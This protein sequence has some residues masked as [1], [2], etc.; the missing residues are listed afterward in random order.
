MINSSLFGKLR[1]NEFYFVLICQTN[2]MNVPAIIGFDKSGNSSF[3]SFNKGNI[4]ADGIEIYIYD[5]KTFVNVTNVYVFSRPIGVFEDMN[6]E[7]EGIFERLTES[8]KNFNSSFDI[9]KH[10]IQMYGKNPGLPVLKPSLF[11]ESK[12]SSYVVPSLFSESNNSSY[13]VPSLFSESGSETSLNRTSSKLKKKK[14][15]K[16]KSPKKKSPK[17]NF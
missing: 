11:S 13:V 4:T 16:K 17:K 8:S 10:N 15:P 7:E 5:P 12:K 1:S 6:K 3:Y 9:Q 2:N 14:S